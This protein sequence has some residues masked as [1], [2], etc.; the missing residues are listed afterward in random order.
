M[1]KGTFIIALFIAFLTLISCDEKKPEV[2]HTDAE[3][4]ELRSDSLY[5]V[6][7]DTIF[8]NFRFGMSRKE[9]DTLC[10]S[11]KKEFSGNIEGGKNYFMVYPLVR[12]ADNDML[13]I[14]DSCYFYN[15]SLY[16]LNVSKHVGEIWT[17]HTYD[18]WVPEIH[19]YVPRFKT[20]YYG[21]DGVGVFKEVRTCLEKKYGEPSA[22]HSEKAE[23]TRLW[24]AWHFSH[25]DI[26]INI[27]KISVNDYILRIKFVHKALKEKVQKKKEARKK[28]LEE[29]REAERKREQARED[30]INKKKE[31]F[32]KGL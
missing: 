15:D 30:S 10:D 5:K 32:A 25:K 1:K 27:V 31:S 26:Y 24:A 21:Y 23:K 11:I 3:I 19:S 18:E 28:K 7:G 13:I 4:M 6:E 14:T 22:S 16:L 20:N 9:F 17:E 8:G 12:I 29:K 2:R